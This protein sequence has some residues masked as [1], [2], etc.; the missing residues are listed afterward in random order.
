MRRTQERPITYPELLVGGP[1]SGVLDMVLRR[2][3]DPVDAHA[4]AERVQFVKENLAVQLP[5]SRANLDAY[6]YWALHRWDRAG[7][8]I[9]TMDG[10]LAWAIANTE[11]PMTTFDLL[12]EV[13]VD[14]MYVSMP[15]VFDIG[16]DEIGRHRIE[17][18]FM[19]VN[20]IYVPVDGRPADGPVTMIGPDE[21]HKYR[22]K[23]GITVVGVGEDHAP[24]LSERIAAGL[25][26]QRDDW[27]VY[28]NLVPGEAL[29]IDA[30]P[31]G[32][33]ELTRVVSNFLYLL[34][35][36]TELREE[37]DPPRP[38]CVGNDRKARRE[39]ERQNRKGRSAYP[40]RVWHLSTL[41]RGK[42]TADPDAPVADN[43]QRKVSGHVVLGHIH[44]YWVLDP[45]GRRSLGTREV[46][47]KTRGTR[48]YHLVAKW[49]LPYVRG[50]GPVAQARVRV[51]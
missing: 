47:T 38:D 45:S 16:D 22:V 4:M 28:F 34:Q 37:A 23:R 46:A 10:D 7:S 41:E 27:V 26:W 15:P 13:P 2:G 43:P 1:M 50:E 21:A 11:P 9:F 24:N 5:E 12:P 31:Q 25:G 18:F 19:T 36:T 3:S 35:N 17:G 29:Y 48:T 44:R 14:G 8:P 6:L 49:L 40:H 32:V 42:V 33:A 30:G 51:R 39:R 20:D